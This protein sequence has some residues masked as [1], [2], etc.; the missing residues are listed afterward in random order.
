MTHNSP[1]VNNV[2]LPPSSA[3]LLDFWPSKVFIMANLLRMAALPR[4]Y[5][6]ITCRRIQT[7]AARRY[8]PVPMVRP[9]YGSELAALQA[10]EKGPWTELTKQEKIDCKSSDLRLHNSTLPT[11]LIFSY[12]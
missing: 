4:L 2:S 11:V 3:I 8:E 1:G 7:S 10:K 9:D 5:A 12:D 6:R